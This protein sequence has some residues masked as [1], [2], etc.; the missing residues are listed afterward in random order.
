MAA[1]EIARR[2]SEFADDVVKALIEI[3]PSN[4]DSVPVDAASVK[5]PGLQSKE[6]I[7]TTRADPRNRWAIVA[8][9]IVLLSIIARGDLVRHSIEAAA[10]FS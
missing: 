3:E 10:H 8:G 2:S 7:A 1:G 9:V 5:L 4:K 6:T